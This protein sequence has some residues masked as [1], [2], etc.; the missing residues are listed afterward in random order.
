MKNTV[1]L[2]WDDRAVISP[3][4]G[5]LDAPRSLSVFEQVIADL[6]TL[7]G[8]R[9]QTIIC[10][11]HPVYVSSRWARRAGV[12]VIMV[13]HHYA[14]ASALAGE[15]PDVRNWL[16]FTWDGV[17]YGGDGT[18]WGGE[19]LLGSPGA[20]RRVGSLRPFH[21]PGGEKAGREPWRS[22]LSLCWEAGI[23]WKQCPEDPMLAHHAWQRRLNCPQTTAAGRLFDAA[24]ALTGLNYRSSYEGQGPMMLEAACADEKAGAIPLPMVL[25][26][27]GIRETDWAPLLPFL[28][29]EKHSLA[30]RAGGFHA[31]LAQAIVAQANAAREEHGELT[32]GLSGGVFQNRV[33]TEH[34]LTLLRA[35]GFDVRLTHE[36]PCNDAGISFGQ[37]I[38]TGMKL[39]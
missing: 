33:L 39:T 6:Q 10:D 2:A 3:H 18:L 38:E 34:T 7:Y 9:A 13:L 15:H 37:I 5:D 14:H 19:T 31:S 12:P 35:S 21:V 23:E 8:V 25:N 22:A 36:I 29:N 16:V 30:E 32:V 27:Q 11:A 17:G 26:R 1:T 24:A 20:W 4:I 28:M